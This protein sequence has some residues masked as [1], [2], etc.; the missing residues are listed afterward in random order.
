MT[1]RSQI[2]TATLVVV[3]GL[4]LPQPP[5]S[6]EEPASSLVTR[7]LSAESKGQADERN[8]LL[9]QAVAS[10]PDHAAA[11]GLLGEIAADGAWRMVDA[12]AAP[13]EGAVAETLA[14][15][16]RRRDTLT[17][18]ET[19]QYER[20]LKLSSASD[21]RAVRYRVQRELAAEHAEL[22]LWCEK[23]GLAEEARA[24][25]TQAV[26]LDPSRD[27]TWKRL[28]YTQVDGR[29]LSA[30]EANDAKAQAASQAK[31]DK[32]WEP[33]LR[34]TKSALAGKDRGKREAAEAE[35]AT[36]ADPQAVPMLV[37]VFATGSEV[38]AHRA[39]RILA[40][41]D[42]PGSTR[43]L[44][45]LAVS[46][47]S[48]LI[49]R[50]ATE[51]LKARDAADYGAILVN[52]VRSP[53][54]Y[55]VQSEVTGPGSRGV[56]QV[57]APQ[58]SLTKAYDAPAV[59]RVSPQF[60]GYIGYGPSG[61]PMVLSGNE[62]SIK[63]KRTTVPAKDPGEELSRASRN[64]AVMREA[65][66]RTTARVIEAQ[67]QALAAQQVMASDIRQI[68]A[69]NSEATVLN[70]RISDVMQ[71]TLAAP[72]DLGDDENAWRRWWY[73]QNGYTYEPPEKVQVFQSIPVLPP[74]LVF[75]CFAA[76]TPVRTING[77]APIESLRVGDKVLAQDTATGALAFRPIVATHHNP[78]S[79]TVRI[80]LEG[81]EE[82]LV[83]SRFHR[84][85]VAGEGWRQARDLEPGDTL[86][87]LGHTSRITGIESGDVQPV[88]NL[89]VADDATFFVG[90]TQALV[91]DNS[92]P[93]SHEALF[94]ALP[95][96]PELAE[97][98]RPGS[99]R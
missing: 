12:A 53:W 17:I 91:H 7:A 34:R 16:H 44:A 1:A 49:R 21:V 14:D 2:A 23:A 15:Y 54:E 46:H 96:T 19:R 81:S 62:L 25:C 5:A 80:T 84:F 61:L 92:I 3:L 90:R 6:G 78:P 47:D 28:G 37:E 40:R 87:T 32:K 51:V 31:A 10:D 97:T 82:S 74:P 57:E 72:A 9:R 24:H 56:L 85:W 79:E 64:L 38:D 63:L 60:C 99:I 36:I 22:G 45:A 66:A 55:S 95:A 52:W 98:A 69:H 89:S 83:A 50:E 59:L 42:V 94:D 11:R 20:L 71:F 29:W 4:M 48:P 43:A 27:Q 86:R 73:E 65:E 68:E 13:A 70:E 77:P 35:L 88:Y 67:G 76:G 93:G 18:H 75:S 58:F 8:T 26:R 41:L 39:I 30:Q 33:V